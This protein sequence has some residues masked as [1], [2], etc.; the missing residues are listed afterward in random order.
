MPLMV[1]LSQIEQNLKGQFVS[2][3]GE[4]QG[5][6]EFTEWQAKPFHERYGEEE[7]NQ[8]APT[9]NYLLGEVQGLANLLRAAPWRIGNTPEHRA[10]VHL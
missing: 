10:T 2:Q 5:L 9:T 1:P 6:A 7:P 8:P 3:F 4:T